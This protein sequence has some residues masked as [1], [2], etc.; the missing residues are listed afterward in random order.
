MSAPVIGVDWEAQLRQLQ[1][2]WDSDGG[3]RITDEAIEA[4]KRKIFLV[5]RSD[6]GICLDIHADG[7]DV[8]IDFGPDGAIK[9]ASVEELN[10]CQ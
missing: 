5:P 4:V 6:G 10:S 9:D 2:D 7:F 8:I 1:P 3:K